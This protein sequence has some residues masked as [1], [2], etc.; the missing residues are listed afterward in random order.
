MSSSEELI[1]G[2]IEEVESYLPSLKENLQ[3]LSEEPDQKDLLQEIYRMTHTIKGASGMVGI[4]GLSHIAFEME[5]V[6]ENCL[7][8]N[9][10]VSQEANAAM[11]RTVARFE[12]YC[13]DY[14][15]SGVPA[16]TLLEETLLDFRPVRGISE[17]TPLPR[18]LLDSVPEIEGGSF[19]ADT[20]DESDF[21]SDAERIAPEEEIPASTEAAD[22]AIDS[23]LMESFYDEAEDHLQ[24]IGDAIDKLEERVS[25]SGPVS[26]RDREIL[27]RIRRSVHTLKGAAAV[28]G[29]SGI[30][31]FAHHYEDLLDRLYEN[32]AEISPST[33]SVLAESSDLLERMVADPAA[34]LGERIQRLK[35]RFKRLA[36]AGAETAAQ[37]A[38][39]PETEIPADTVAQPGRPGRTLRVGMERMD[40][41]VNL[42]GEIII[43]GSAFDQRMETFA[44]GVNELEIA[45]NRLRELAKEMEVGFEVKA[46]AR[47]D[48]MAAAVRNG[49]TGE[50]GPF[51]GYDEFDDLELDRYSQLNLI[52]RT[53]N[54]AVID[55]GTLHTQFTG[56]YSDFDG[57][58]TRQRVLLSELQEKMMRVRL[59]PMRAIV[60]RLRRTL[61]EAAAQLNKKIGL[62]IEGE[63][64]ELDRGVWERMIDPLMHILRN[65]ADHAIEPPEI[66]RARGKPETGTVQLT[67]AREGNQVVIRIRDD[68]A[69]LDYDAIRETVRAAKLSESPDKLADEE[70]VS[71]IFYPGFST[72]DQISHLSG[73]GVGMDVVR[74]NIHELKGT[75]RV[76]SDSGG[77][78]RFTIRIPLTLAAVQALLFTVKGQLLAIPLNEIEEILRIDPEEITGERGDVVRINEEVLP[79][80]DMADVLESA[81]EKGP[82]PAQEQP[83]VLV[84]RSAERRC[85]L[86]IDALVGQREIVIKGTGSH[87]RYVRGVSGVTIMGD[88]SVVPILNIGELIWSQEEG[89]EPEEVRAPVSPPTKGP[90]EI[91]VVDDSVSIRQVVSR[92]IQDQGWRAHTA[93]DGIDALERLREIRPDL[94]V[95]DIEMPRMNGYEF[96]SAIKAEPSYKE[97]PVLMLTSRTAAKHRNRALSLGAKGFVVKPYQH[98]AFVEAM[99]SLAKKR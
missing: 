36:G 47:M 42:T 94:I 24:E 23:I 22:F 20:W 13:T 99:S 33:V 18:E 19:D 14:L 45:R 81:G 75:I 17:H 72:R 39:D 46:L 2:Y 89:V 84:V 53:L 70:L 48:R 40:E 67:A 91:L 50:T 76:R 82:P 44:E 57:G 49:T 85:A 11:R 3:R 4:P 29:L 71:Y 34:H 21:E 59:T 83:L 96:L 62:A 88:G 52:I 5:D 64:I 35:A 38:S 90:T 12:A 95:L 9:L 37:P 79:L 28:I 32:E 87:L 74:E 16:R 65:A 92:L 30:S 58:L 26:D 93:K 43:S 80:F 7:N 56:I 78:T 60:S 63:E 55:V 41:L 54:E 66:R 77:G 69:G 15:G 31:G 86:I 27:G 25:E 97:I 1:R 61:R 8:K 98:E 6:C 68:G 51:F 10:P 73:R